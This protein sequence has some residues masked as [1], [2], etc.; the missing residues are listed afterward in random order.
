L[1]PE[2]LPRVENLIGMIKR[3]EISIQTVME[4]VASVVGRFRIDATGIEIV[5]RFKISA[6]EFASIS[7]TLYTILDILPLLKGKVL[8]INLRG[9]S[10]FRIRVG[11]PLDISP[12]HGNQL[13]TTGLPVIDLDIDRIPLLFQEQEGMILTLL[14]PEKLLKIHNFDVLLDWLAA[15]WRGELKMIDMVIP[16][17]ALTRKETAHRLHEPLTSLRDEVLARCGV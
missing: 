13:E 9:L 10:T 2:S 8:Y 5:N 17:V 3:G 14:G 4:N 16:L 1:V 6:S 15:T 12:A 11:L 7:E